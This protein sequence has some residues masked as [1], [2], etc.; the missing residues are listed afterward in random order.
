M[1]IS[2]VLYSILCHVS[3]IGIM[4]FS[5]LVCHM[6]GKTIF[7]QAIFDPIS[8]LF[9]GLGVILGAW[10]W[11]IIHKIYNPYF[12][13]VREKKTINSLLV[14]ASIT[15][16]LNAGFI[17]HELLID[18]GVSE[19]IANLVMTMIIVTGIGFGLHLQHQFK[20]EKTD[21]H[22]KN[23]NDHPGDFGSNE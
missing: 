11:R 3:G 8:L 19:D 6:I 15:T 13:E 9:G 14:A 22:H 18:L 5:T 21:V 12:N 4:L 16:G 1:K 17:Y 10:I 20:K 23:Q 7:D 2:H